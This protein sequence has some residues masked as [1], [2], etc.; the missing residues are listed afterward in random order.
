MATPPTEEKP[1]TGAELPPTRG[2]TGLAMPIQVELERS[3][4]PPKPDQ[5]L[6]QAIKTSTEYVGF[7]QYQHFIDA[8]MTGH[9]PDP[10]LE[11]YSVEKERIKDLAPKRALP[12]PGVDAY[13]LLK[14]AT[15]VFL[16]T[17]CGITGFERAPFETGGVRSLPDH[18]QKV[19]DELRRY[20]IPVGGERKDGAATPR[21][22]GNRPRA[23]TTSVPAIPYLAI[24]QDK[25]RDV[26]LVASRD[27]PAV[28]DCYFILQEK[29]SHPC[30]VELIW[31]YWHEEAMLVQ[32][33]NA[34]SRRFQNRRA[35]GDG[36]ALAKLDLDPLR[37]L[38]NIMW[39]YLQDEQHH[40]TVVRRAYEYEHTYGFMLQGRAVQGLRPAEI[41]SRFLEAFHNLLH[42]ASIFYKSDDDT[43]VKA[44]AFPVLN[45]LKEVHFILAE[46]A[47]NQFGDLQ[48][49]ARGEMLMQM[50]LLARPEMREFIGGRVMV[51]YPEA[52]M[53]RVDTMKSLLGW[54]DVSVMH[55]HDLAV[56]GEQLLLS[57]R[58]GAWSLVDD[59][60]DAAKWGREWRL[61]VFQYI[62]AYRAVTGVDLSADSG[63]DIDA[64]PPSEHLQRRLEEQQSQRRL[65]PAR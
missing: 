39:G 22:N 34:I 24:I 42:R 61:Q 63:T 18:E 21:G 14:V 27:D 62:H 45:A 28:R 3:S 52:W 43:T 9:D 60:E 50:W 44:D 58:Y 47:N 4:V 12:F 13:R 32:T 65:P 36:D 10:A 26:P 30:M 23:T 64:R 31:C 46:G 51:P 38:A 25:L 53:D 2:D 29:L 59:M 8:V 1:L 49:T 20:L 54:T 11:E 6:W 48:S 7:R 55:F 15:E 37:P 33:M 56:Y 17:H 40:L 35:N 19:M 41:R 57:V 16:M 5:A